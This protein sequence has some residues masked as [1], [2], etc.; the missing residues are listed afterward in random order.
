MNEILKMFDLTLIDAIMIPIGSLMFLVFW[1]TF[2]MG[3]VKP[4]ADLVAERE[5]ATLGAE[6]RSSA[7][8]AEASDLRE[9]FEKQVTNARIEHLKL[10]FEAVAKSKAAAAQLVAQAESTAE[11]TLEQAHVQAET[12]LKELRTQAMRESDGLAQ[13][14]ADKARGS[15]L[16]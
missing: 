3:V 14:F 2:G 8:R 11:K 4:F 7:V 9:N 13:A 1:R 15:L 16:A 6:D 5:Q 10:K 12:K